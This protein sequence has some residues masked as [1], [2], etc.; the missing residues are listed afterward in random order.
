MLQAFL[1][2]ANWAAIAVAALTYFFIGA[3]WYSPLLFSKIWAEGHGIVVSDD[4]KKKMPLIFGTTFFIGAVM[5]VALAVI[6]FVFQST[7]CVSGIKVGLLCGVGLAIG[8]MTMNFLYH[9]KSFK[10]FLID[11]GYHVISVVIMSIIISIWK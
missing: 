3:I 9:R 10:L 1:D 6:I 5:A 4:D 2:H 7:K 11:A 8:P